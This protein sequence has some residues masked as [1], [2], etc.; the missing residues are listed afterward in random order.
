[1]AKT[2]KRSSK[3]EV[4]PGSGRG[5]EGEG[6][7][8]EGG[9]EGG[10]REVGGREGGGREGGREGGKEGGRDVLTFSFMGVK[11]YKRKVRMKIVASGCGHWGIG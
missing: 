1:M 2:E 3:E 10:G 5:R 8:G 11:L 7:E 9:R 6:R 4:T